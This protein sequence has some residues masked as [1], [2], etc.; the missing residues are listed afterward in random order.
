MGVLDTDLGKFFSAP[1]PRGLSNFNQTT[2]AI[3]DFGL[4]RRDRTNKKTGAT[5]S[6]FTVSIDATPLTHHCDAVSLG[7]GPANAIAEH[8]RARIRGITADAT[9]ATVARRKSAARSFEYGGH[10]PPITGKGKARKASKVANAKFHSD[11]ETTSVMARYS[12]GRMGPMAPNTQ[13]TKLFNDSGRLAQSLIAKPAKP[14]DPTGEKKAEW[15]INIAANRFDPSTFNGGEVALDAM[16]QRLLTYVPE[17]G[18]PQMLMQVGS[19]KQAVVD[20]Y[21]AM[22]DKQT[23]LREK[24][25][26]AQMSAFKSALTLF[27]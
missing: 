1:K 16:Y 18:D 3:N 14:T 23:D 21:K 12:G 26:R 4:Q 5:K 27:R 7:R 13:G 8:L 24:L 22:F 10:A 2:V 9:D 15:V 11:M 17:M 25:A 20:S 6:R 19:V